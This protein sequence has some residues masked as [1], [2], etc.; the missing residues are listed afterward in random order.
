MLALRL[1]KEIEDRLATLAKRTG[2]TKS[3]VARMAI[4]EQMDDIEDALLAEQA[5]ADASAKRFS[6]GDIKAD[7]EADERGATGPLRSE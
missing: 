2:R 1:P 3:H 7:L 6:L 5:L 4:I